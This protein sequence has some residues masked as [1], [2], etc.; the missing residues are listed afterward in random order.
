M[1]K[2]K[3]VFLI[4]LI[5]FMAVSVWGLLD[6][7]LVDDE[8][9]EEAIARLIAAHEA[10]ETSHLGVGE[11]LQSHK[12]SEVID[13]VVDSIIEDKIKDGEVT[14]NKLTNNQIIS[15]DFRTAANVGAGVDGVKYNST[16]IEM[17]QSG[18]KRVDIPVS[19]D[20]SFKGKVTMESYETTKFIINTIFE[21]LDTWVYSGT[22]S[23]GKLNIL[24]AG[25]IEIGTGNQTNDEY[26]LEQAFFILQTD[27][28]ND[29]PIMSFTLKLTEKTK[30]SFI[31]SFG[32]KISAF[33]NEDAGFW[34][35][36]P[37]QELRPFVCHSGSVNGG[38]ITGIDV[39]IPHTY[40]VEHTVTETKFFI[41]GVLKH[42]QTT[43]LPTG[44]REAYWRVGF[45][46]SEAV[47]H[48]GYLLEGVYIQ[49]R[50]Y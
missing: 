46:T 25:A 37:S 23:R 13:H 27:F 33:I 10:D 21:S 26:M 28:D 30:T 49:T 40:R 4:L 50:D 31:T 39:T 16:G 12:A 24:S 48:W 41:D 11:S 3:N 8:T 9:I 6:K 38:V 2:I 1:M 47:Q 45:R 34:W 22:G 7:S 43:G 5:I 15:K 20:P 29:D 44:K 42:T 14:S 32:S 17:W 19:G 18:E 35:D 36:A